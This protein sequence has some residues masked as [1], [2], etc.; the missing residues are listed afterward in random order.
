MLLLLLLLSFFSSLL[1]SCCRSCLPS[2][3]TSLSPLFPPP[4]SFLPSIPFISV[5][6]L[7]PL[8][9]RSSTL[10]PPPLPP[11]LLPFLSSFHPHLPVRRYPFILMFFFIICIYFS[12]HLPPLRCLTFNTFTEHLLFLPLLS[13]FTSVFL[14]VCFCIVSLSLYRIRRLFSVRL[15]QYCLL[16]IDRPLV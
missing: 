3:H 15:Y 8:T 13:S 7:L 10:T 1:F 4:Q 6:S 2:L 11:S 16:R 9:S 14:S 12:I 5:I